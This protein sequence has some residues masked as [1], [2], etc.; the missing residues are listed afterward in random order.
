M[1]TM[2]TTVTRRISAAGQ[3]DV[4]DQLAD[5]ETFRRDVYKGL[6]AEQ[7][8]LQCKYPVR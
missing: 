6:E 4:N 5:V 7:K 2:E 8:F 3:V 1:E